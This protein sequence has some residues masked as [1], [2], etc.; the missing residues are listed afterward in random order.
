M[1]RWLFTIW[2]ILIV[3]VQTNFTAQQSFETFKA[4]EERVKYTTPDSL[5]IFA[6]SVDTASA[7][8]RA[9]KHWSLGKAAFWQ[10]SYP[11][12]YVHLE[13]TAEVIKEINSPVL[14]AE[15]NLDL[16]DALAVVDQNGKALSHLLEA[17]EILKDAGTSSQQNR[18]SISLGEMYRKIGE[19]E[20]ALK[21]LRKTLPKVRGDMHNHARCLNR[22]AAVFSETDKKDSSLNYSYRALEIAGSINEPNLMATSENEIGYVL[23]NQQKYEAS[24]PH[25]F[26]A[27]SLWRSV[28]MLRYAIN[29]MHH[30]SVVYGSTY[31]IDK[32]L[33]ITRKAYQLIKGKGWYQIETSLMEDLKSF[34]Y[35]LGNEDSVL[36]YDRERLQAVV[37]WRGEQHE[38]NTRMVEI[39]YTQK[40]NEQTIR[41]QEISLKNEMLEKKAINRERNTLWIIILLTGLILFIIVVYVYNQRKLQQR[42]KEENSEREKK[43]EQLINALGANEALVQ[44]ISHRVKNNLAVLSGLLN[45]QADRSEDDRVKKELTDSVLRIDSIATIHKK[46]Y[47]KR[48]DAKVNLKEA[49]EE[50]SSN[51]VSAM[52]K[53]PETCLITAIDDLEIDIAPAVT[54]C[55]MINEAIT[56][57]CK[58]GE[59]SQTKKLRVELSS[60][61]NKVY[62]RVIDRGPGFD[63]NK[64][65]TTTESLG[66]YLIKLLARQLKSRIEW[67][68]EDEQFI[69]SIELKKD[70]YL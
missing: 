57:S 4:L 50:L 10:S 13:K 37:N 20:N 32:G 24:L 61:V 36:F 33:E 41:E 38:V 66:I 42:L 6:E 15:I 60:E 70:D 69:M 29:P 63:V 30:I 35:H 17:R 3:G 22:M 52:G 31:Q 34:H 2:L 47:D 39:L 65:N 54:L 67:R 12:A 7:F 43:N 44:E 28:G 59:I 46:L 64:V 9:L 53:N 48:S 55:L 62:C 40:E 25:F 14:L 26:R 18:A 68:K 51:V 58:Y 8:G 11:K 21:I 27:D 5:L 45:M 1:R 56:N 16:A 23:R 49:L 19:F